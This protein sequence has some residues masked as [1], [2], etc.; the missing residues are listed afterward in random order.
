MCRPQQAV[1]PAG[2]SSSQRHLLDQ[3]RA[4]ILTQMARAQDVTVGKPIMPQLAKT[5][6]TP[7]EAF[8]A[9]KGRPF[10]L[11]TKFDGEMCIVIACFAYTTGLPYLC[12]TSRFPS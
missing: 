11:E 7:Q 1:A 5:V 6:F 10:L 2:I 8:D 3:A 4:H 12:D 9:V